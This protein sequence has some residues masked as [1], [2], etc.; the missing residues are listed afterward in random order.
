MAPALT[1]RWPLAAAAV[2]ALLALAGVVGH[3]VL[4][5]PARLAADKQS[6]VN[7]GGTGAAP[8]DSAALAVNG[9]LGANELPLLLYCNVTSPCTICAPSKECAGF[10]CACFPACTQLA[11]H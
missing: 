4:G 8:A 5:L 11:D 1:T 3:R 6:T 10:R 2:I 7:H 9:T